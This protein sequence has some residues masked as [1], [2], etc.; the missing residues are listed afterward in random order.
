M[1]TSSSLLKSAGP[2][3]FSSTTGP[4]LFLVACIALT[5]CSG[6]SD[7]LNGRNTSTSGSIDRSGGTTT[8][9]PPS[10]PA[11][12]PT[13]TPTVNLSAAS[14]VLD[15]G[16]STSLSWSSTDATACTASGGWTGNRDTSG[17]VSVGPVSQQTTFSLSCSG[18][19]GS[20][21]AMVSVSV[22]GT[23][24][25]SWVAPTENVDGS[26]L[27]DLAGYRVYYGTGSR[28]YTTMRDVPGASTTST[29]LT[30]SSG[31][32]YVAMTA[33]D[34]EGNE[35]AYSNEVIKTVL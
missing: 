26:A 2:R 11:G 28:S 5:A 10:D 21:L 22:R 31:D 20:A 25:L 29:S 4:V 30:L 7:P 17:S 16:G 1:S 23:V 15:S 34:G 35:S 12:T 19:G 3:G 27:T 9:P 18:D 32:Y 6:T 14:T 13:A 33:L 8:A 24:T